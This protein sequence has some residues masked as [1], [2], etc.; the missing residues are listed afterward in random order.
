MVS[1]AGPLIH[2]AQIR[3][4]ILLKKLFDIVLITE[5]VKFEVCDEGLRL[6]YADAG[7]IAAALDDGW[8]KVEPF[9]KRLAA[10]ALKFAQGEN[11]SKADAQTLLL[12]VDKKA[13]LLV[14]ERLLSSLAKM[15]GLKVWSTW[16]LLLEALSKNCIAFADVKIA[17]DDL[18]KR[19]FRLNPK[20]TQEIL[21]AAKQIDKQQKCGKNL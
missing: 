17:V 21:E 7:S 2:L 11:I 19:K 20:Q 9:P 1:D 8:L 12:A 4:L 18:G 16:T 10:S 5:K 13:K 6:G 3:Q 14:D 15:Y